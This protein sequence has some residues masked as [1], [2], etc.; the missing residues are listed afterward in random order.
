MPDDRP[1]VYVPLVMPSD[2][3]WMDPRLFGANIFTQQTDVATTLGTPELIVP[4]N[5]N[6]WSLLLA[7]APISGFGCSVAPFSDL[8]ALN[9]IP[10]PSPG[11]LYYYLPVHGALVQSAWYAL[12]GLG[13]VCRV[14]EQIRR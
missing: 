1:P 3:A 13:S 10:L 7:N 6:R 11:W 8:T 4:A 2:R 12:G 14:V 9:A 5:P